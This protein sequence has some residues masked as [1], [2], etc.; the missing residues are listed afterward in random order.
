MGGVAG[1]LEVNVLASGRVLA[2][3]RCS[4]EARAHLVPQTFASNNG[5]FI[6]N[7]LVGLEVQ[8]QLWVVTLNYDFGRFLDGLCANATLCF[9]ETS[10][11]AKFQSIQ[12][13]TTGWYIYIPLLL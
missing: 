7:A 2:G 12:I 4:K 5:D 1:N 8:G 13:G 9:A 10:A 3:E 6:A 11:C